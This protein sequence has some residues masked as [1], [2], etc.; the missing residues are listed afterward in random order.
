MTIAICMILGGTGSAR[1]GS[2]NVGNTG[3][4][5]TACEEAPVGVESVIA[6]VR[7]VPL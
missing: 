4:L 2:Y 6:G 5:V 1:R 3:M 7:G